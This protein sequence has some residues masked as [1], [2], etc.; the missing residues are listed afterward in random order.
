MFANILIMKNETKNSGIPKVVVVG[1][2]FGGL[3]LC[4][5]LTNGAFNVT[6]IN[7]DNYHQFQPL[8]YQVASSALE[9]STIAFP[10]RKDLR[11]A[12]NITFRYASL[13]SVDDV[14]KKVTT[15]SGDIDYDYLIIATGTKTNYY[16]I[17]SIRKNAIPMK[18]IA[19][20]IVLRNHILETMERA[21]IDPQSATL[22]TITI[23]GGGATGVEIAG[24]LAEMRR[25]AIRKEYPELKDRALRIILIEASGKL[26]GMM[27]EKASQKALYALQKLGVE[28][29]LNT[30]VKDYNDNSVVTANG[31]SIESA[32]L[33]WVSGVVVEKIDGLR[34]NVY[35]RGGRIVVDQCNQV[36]GYKDIFAIGDCSIM[37]SDEWPNGHP[38]LAPV[39]IQQGEL[40]AK[41]L[42]Q[43]ALN[44][45]PKPFKYKN[46]GSMATIGRG[47]AV[48][49]IGRLHLSGYA[50]WLT[51]LF[52]HLISIL[53]IKNKIETLLNWSW[54][55]IMLDQ[56]LR[57]II[58]P[59]RGKQ[60]TPKQ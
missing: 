46:R 35:S 53:G 30:T 1:G 52:V 2:G 40:L 3:K 48:A 39:A 32:T 22:R 43:I 55:Y 51:W 23:V 21:A 6:L 11:R 15:S 59:E 14:A 27:S 56:S 47:K 17:E 29:R 41:N 60:N 44:E 5:S 54:S 28:V 42:H 8:I 26:L 25:Y 49:D 31:E 7:E 4:K 45:E 16:G 57:L 10:L 38:Q 12:S 9:P 24:A 50:A 13:I 36:V 34:E 20:A 33:I 18:S 37:P 19:E 58:R